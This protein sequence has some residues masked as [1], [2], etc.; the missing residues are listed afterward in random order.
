MSFIN[1]QFEALQKLSRTILDNDRDNTKTIRELTNELNTYKSELANALEMNNL[2]DKVL[3]VATN[4]IRDKQ[5]P[6]NDRIIELS[7][8]LRK[9][10]SNDTAIKSRLLAITKEQPKVDTSFV[11]NSD[12]EKYE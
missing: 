7:E 4:L 10:D 12:K 2:G 1:D 3:E 9:R 8:E 6:F 5:S 11:D